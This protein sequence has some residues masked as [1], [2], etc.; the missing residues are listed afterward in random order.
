VT[1]LGGRNPPVGGER[2][3]G[4][5]IPSVS[6]KLHRNDNLRRGAD[7]SVCAL[8]CDV[9]KARE[10]GSYERTDRLV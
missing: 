10:R 6:L 7:E 8:A 4:A 2:G 5:A 9:A 1:V 3:V